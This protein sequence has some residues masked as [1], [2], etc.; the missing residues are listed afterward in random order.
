MNRRPLVRLST[1]LLLTW[2]L[3]VSLAP[4]ATGTG[5]VSCPS[6]S[7]LTETGYNQCVA[8]GCACDPRT[9]YCVSKPK[10]VPVPACPAVSCL[11]QTG[12]EQCVAAGCACDPKTD[13]CVPAKPVSDSAF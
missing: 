11:S 3:S 10:P 8:A 2:G 1:L 6:V 13:A 4:A 12:Y 5:P 9:D 7:C